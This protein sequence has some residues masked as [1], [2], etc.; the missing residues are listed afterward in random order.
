MPPDDELEQVVSALTRDVEATL[1]A[2]QAHIVVQ[3][4]RDI[5]EWM[6]HGDWFAAKLVEEVQQ[7]FHDERVD[8]TW[9]ACPRHP[10]H[11][12]WLRDGW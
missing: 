11:P 12:L 4:A 8:T 2:G 7:R 3:T 9:P 1:G 5:L 10:W 6:E